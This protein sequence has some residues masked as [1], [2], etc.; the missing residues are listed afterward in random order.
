LAEIASPAVPDPRQQSRPGETLEA[1]EPAKPNR[2]RTVYPRCRHHL[3]QRRR[4][5]RHPPPSPG[6]QRTA[7]VNPGLNPGLTLSLC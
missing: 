2:A 3:D 1:I 7:E 5:H 6:H 4:R